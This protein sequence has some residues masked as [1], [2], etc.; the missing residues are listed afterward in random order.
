M[1]LIIWIGLCVGVGVFA[2]KK[3][4]NGFLWFII[5]IFI[6]PII[7]GVIVALLKDLTNEANI[8]QLKMEQQSTSDR[9]ASDERLYDHRLNKVEKDVERIQ[10]SAEGNLK[11]LSTNGLQ[12]LEEGTKKC[13]YCGEVIKMGAIK[14][15]HCSETIETVQLKECPFCKEEVRADAIICKHCKSSLA[16]HKEEVVI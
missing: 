10:D 15:K 4:R 3:G 6:S 9:L 12:E 13:P 14:C 16:S 11:R 8:Q 2:S 1:E 5:S 7:G